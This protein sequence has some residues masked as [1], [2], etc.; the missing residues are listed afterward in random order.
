MI[1]DHMVKR[2]NPLFLYHFTH[3]SPIP[4]PAQNST[5]AAFVANNPSTRLVS[6]ELNAKSRDR[7]YRKKPNWNDRKYVLKAVKKSGLALRYASEDFKKDREI[8]LKAVKN[9]GYALD[10]AS[11][12]LKNDREFILEAVKSNGWALQYAWEGFKNDRK[13]VLEAVMSIGE[14]LYY[15]SEGFKN[16]RE[17]VLEAVKNNGLAL[18]YASEDLKNDRE[19]VLE[20][21]KNC[22]DNR[23]LVIEA[24]KYYGCAL[25]YA[26]DD[27]KKDREIVLEA[28]K[29]N[30]DA[31]QFASED[32]K[33]D[34]EL[35]LIA[36]Y[37]W[38][39]IGND[40]ISNLL[41]QEQRDLLSNERQFKLVNKQE[42]TFD[43]H[44]QREAIHFASE[45][46]FASAIRFILKETKNIYLAHTTIDRDGN[47]YNRPLHR[48]AK[49]GHLEACRILLDYGGHVNTKKGEPTPLVL[50]EQAKLDLRDDAKRDEF[51][52][53][54]Q[55]LK[56][57]NNMIKTGI[58]GVDALK[59]ALEDARPI[60]EVE[61]RTCP[62]PGVG[63]LFGGMHSVLVITVS[64][65][66]TTERFFVENVSD[67]NNIK[68]SFWREASHREHQFDSEKIAKQ[69]DIQ[70]G[71]TMKKT[72]R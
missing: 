19:I 55:F 28:V 37:S 14:A 34:K 57:T 35:I 9:H 27:L 8:V 10:Y 16:D 68:V 62:L 23:N 71:V 66:D 49:G 15:A 41:S 43:E 69:A 72:L 48:A 59:D 22:K 30:G 5:V 61:W 64:D 36:L 53:V 52:K 13:I 50:A 40:N 25:E 4:F 33:K 7:K 46:G 18:Y 47:R 3:T 70:E 12:D 44:F 31:L 17:I 26:S 67:M 21:V 54:I 24:V 63:N 38:Y 11:E 1:A 51:D 60:V 2:T 39:A 42:N 56:S 32:F 20:A 58:G 45:N 6:T 65:F 29:K